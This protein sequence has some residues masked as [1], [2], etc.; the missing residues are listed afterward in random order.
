VPPWA[1]QPVYPKKM[2]KI[3]M[4]WLKKEQVVETT[5][6]SHEKTSMSN[7]NETRGSCPLENYYFPGKDLI[8]TK[9]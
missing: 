5:C 2:A 6:E 1:A 8:N 9:L 4:K 7:F 3:W